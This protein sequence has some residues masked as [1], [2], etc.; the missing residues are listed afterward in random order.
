[1]IAGIDEKTGQPLALDRIPKKVLDKEDFIKLFITQLEYQD[2]MKPIENNEMAVQLALFNQVDQLFKINETLEKL[3][4]IRK[5][6]DLN[7]A[8][9]LI[10]KY[11]K[12]EGNEGL[13]EDGNFLGGEFEVEEPVNVLNI[14]IRDKNGKVVKN[15]QLNNVTKGV[16]KIEWD[17]TD[18]EGNKVPDGTYTFTI[19]DPTKNPPEEIT[20]T[21]I[22]KITSVVLGDEIKVMANGDDEIK[23]DEIKEILGR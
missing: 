11:V 16:H 18:N 6:S 21:M 2:P 14:T 20:P 10:G 1:M 13:V 23:L 19:T 17:A 9:G 3:M 22:A 4:D 8:T 7:L 5:N 15:I 12:I